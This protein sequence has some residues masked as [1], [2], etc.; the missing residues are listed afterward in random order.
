MPPWAVRRALMWWKTVA[1]VRRTGSDPTNSRKS[2]LKSV[3]QR[4]HMIHDWKH[5]MARRWLTYLQR[6]A[7]RDLLFSPYPG[8]GEPM[9]LEGAHEGFDRHAP[10]KTPRY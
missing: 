2:N 1:M 4:C 10:T 8:R 5:H 7:V 3:C 9:L 6:H